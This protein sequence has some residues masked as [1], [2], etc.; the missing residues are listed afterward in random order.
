MRRPMV[1]T[2][3]V[4]L[5]VLAAGL[6][7]GAMRDESATVDETVFLGAGYSYWKGQRYFFDP[8]H[9]P[10]AQL[11]PAFPL[12]FM[13]LK[14]P[15]QGEALMNG[16]ATSQAAA[17]WNGLPVP[18]AAVFPNGPNFY[19][20]PLYELRYFGEQF[21][22]GGQNDAEQMMFWGRMVEV[23]ITLGAAVLVFCWARRLADDVAGLLAVAM[24]LL[25]P[26][27]LA[28]GHIIQTDAAMALVFPLAAC[29]FGNFLEMRRTR[30]AVLAG[31]ATGVALT[32]KYTA[33]LL[34]PTFVALWAVWCWKQR[35]VK[36]AAKLQRP[37]LGYIIVAAA[38]WGL[39]LLLYFPN[40]APA[41]PPDDQ[42]ARLLHLPDWFISLR[43]LLIPREY[44]KGLAII[45]MH[46]T[47]GHEAYLNGH[48]SHDGWW[49]YFPMALLSKSPLPFLLLVVI[50]MSLA[51]LRLKQMSF[52]EWVPWVAA[53]AY[54]LAA[55]QSKANLGLRHILA[56]YPLVAVGSSVAVALWVNQRK[57]PRISLA[58]LPAWALI[59]AFVAYPL[60][61]P[62]FNEIAGGPANGYRHLVDANYD[63]GQD[64][65]R[66]KRYLDEHEIKHIYY[67]YW[68]TQT[69]KQYYKLPFTDLNDRGEQAQQIQQ[70]YIVVTA[71]WLV[72]PE[73]E[74]LREGHAPVTRVAYTTFVYR[75]P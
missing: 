73:W 34:L 67:A 55:M 42:T 28:H 40:W 35:G 62:Y 33:I 27:V 26:V 25:N 60:F 68:G 7:I 4:V 72:K 17:P 45:L 23:L 46:A 12:L 43:P 8:E 69:G 41:P 24:F 3:L 32:V 13:D 53:A 1:L 64:L 15:P 59:V 5:L 44:F 9:P 19:F 75:L 71:S 58:I 38:A 36:T 49:Y 52:A 54:V 31:L 14:L 57:L 6:M 66:L 21:V 37:W 70:G 18:M 65:I 10:L 47:G 20:Y 61:I 48:W 74:W 63:W 11:L 2:I 30:S 16:R 22:Y 29:A 56:V 39:V 50:G 51:V